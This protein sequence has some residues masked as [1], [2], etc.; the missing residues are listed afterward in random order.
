MWVWVGLS[1]VVHLGLAGVM[2]FLF[3]RPLGGDPGWVAVELVP[4]AT[5]VPDFRPAPLP[6]AR[7][8][9]RSTFDRAAAEALTPTR[10]NSEGAADRDRPTPTEAVVAGAET[11]ALSARRYNHP[12]LDVPARRE[13]RRRANREADAEE[14]TPIMVANPHTPPPTLASAPEGEQMSR[15]PLEAALPGPQPT[16]ASGDARASA[17]NPRRQGGRGALSSRRLPDLLDTARPSGSGAASGRGAGSR[18]GRRGSPAGSDGRPVWLSTPDSRYVDYFRG[19][20]AKVHPLW[21]FPKKLEILMEQGDVLV[22]FTILEDGSIQDVRIR[23]SSGYHE[24]DRNVLAAI[25]KAAP[26]EPIPPRLGRRLTVLAP[27][28]FSNPMVR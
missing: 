26:F 25:Q 17:H 16:E 10:S 21:L 12:S 20:Y 14:P 11:R 2:L 23:K 1:G 8:G 4:P 18:A 24:F 28:E 15:I 22:Q 7:L 9:A 19:I 6:V 5:V 13:R 27:F 3:S